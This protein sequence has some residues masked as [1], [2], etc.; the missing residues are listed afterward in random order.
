MK[1]GQPGNSLE[2][3]QQING[4]R[5]SVPPAADGNRAPAPRDRDPEVAPDPAQTPFA[6]L[7]PDRVLTAIETAGFPCDGRLLALN[8]YENR[9]YR[10]GLEDGDSLIAKFYRSGRWS[11]A[12]IA[13][14]H[15]YA[16]EL[17]A[18][19][20]PVVAPLRRTAESSLWIDQELRFALFPNRPG[21][22]PELEDP[23]VLEWIGRFIGRIHGRGA[24]KRFEVRPALTIERF[25]REPTAYLRDHGFI[26]SELRPAY[27]SVV[28]E[29]LA[30][31][32]T[33][34]E[35]VGPVRQ[36][37]L[38]GDCH[39]GN[40]LWTPAGPHFVDL[41]D[42]MMG[43]AVQDLWMLLAAGEH[44]EMSRLLAHLLKGYTL[45][46]PFEP[47][48]LGLI[49][50][51]R[52]L[53]ILHYAAWLARRWQDPAFPLHFPW[54]NTQRYWQDQILALREQLSAMTEPPLTYV[55]D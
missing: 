53:R 38:H 40:I 51:L 50:A 25:G 14:E 31:I 5:A 37:R 9:V 52:S 2:D 48:E 45:F 6:T 21:R 26:P 16:H 29:L 11:D 55:A 19:E 27:D 24:A 7:T 41:D 18:A 30:Q 8:S 28:D 15:A 35:A 17:F 43:P 20:I 13:E 46:Q 10:V 34:F 36:V 42:C 12:A 44:L 47:A 1:R 23:A 4:N 33:V 54:F 49:E 3:G 32:E 22:T 39:P